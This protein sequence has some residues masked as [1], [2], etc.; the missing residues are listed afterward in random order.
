MGDRSWEIGTDGEDAEL[1]VSRQ[2]PAPL[3]R[4]PHGFS[5][6]VAHPLRSIVIC[7]WLL[8]GI[9][10]CPYDGMS[11]AEFEAWTSR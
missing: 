5:G 2:L 9:A 7:Y 11:P 6:H 4:Y 3:D 10:C 1:I 8:G